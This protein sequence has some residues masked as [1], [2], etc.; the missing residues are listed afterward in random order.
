VR[1]G[2]VWITGTGGVWRLSEAFG[3]YEAWMLAK[4]GRY[5]AI[6]FT[7]CWKTSDDV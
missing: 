3:R 5:D 4:S 1:A 6:C 2:I 7:R